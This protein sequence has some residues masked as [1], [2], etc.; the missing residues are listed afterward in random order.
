MVIHSKAEVICLC[1]DQKLLFLDLIYTILSFKFFK[2]IKKKNGNYRLSVTLT[3]SRTL[4]PWTESETEMTR[5]ENNT[6]TRK[7][8]LNQSK[9]NL[10]SIEE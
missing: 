4:K 3:E 10:F 6:L 8:A 9:N 5:E 7:N 2:I 1:H